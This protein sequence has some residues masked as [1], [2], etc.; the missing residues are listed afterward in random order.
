VHVAHQG[1]A[2]AVGAAIA[3]VSGEVDQVFQR[4][5]RAEALE[6]A[7][8]LASDRAIQA[9]ASSSTISIVEEE[10]IALS[11]LPGNSLR[12]RVRVVGDIAA[13]RSQ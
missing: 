5:S 2:N 7:R 13:P 6:M 9:G 8:T 10:D 3:Q 12:I 1:V 4:M 11:Y